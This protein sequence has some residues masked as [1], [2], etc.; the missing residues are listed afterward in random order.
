MAIIKFQ[1]L[2]INKSSP[3]TFNSA[4]FS[5]SSGQDISPPHQ[6]GVINC[7]NPPPPT[8]TRT[9]TPTKT[10]TPTPTK[11]STPTP[12]KTST[13]TPTKTS[14]PIRTPTPTSTSS[15]SLLWINPPNG[16]IS[17]VGGT[18]DVSIILTDLTGVTAAD[19]S[20]SFDPSV[21]K[22]TTAPLGVIPGSCLPSYI[23]NSVDN[24]TGEIRYVGYR[25]G[26]PCG[27]DPGDANMG[28]IRFQCLRVDRTSPITFTNAQFSDETGS[29]IS[30]PNQGGMI[31]CGNPSETSTPT[32]TPTSTSTPTPAQTASGL[33]YLPICAVPPIDAPLNFMDTVFS[34]VNDGYVLF[35]GWPD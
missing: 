25:I 27:N 20:L 35:Q 9:P 13:P 5:N 29:D 23:I 30:P 6:G 2:A 4:V 18:M 11:T 22:V 14:T 31:S 34:L 33:T 17:T 15:I 7:G 24:V 8:A 28:V 1:C 16:T 10:S 21:L 3:I 32:K 19:L 26:T 12:T